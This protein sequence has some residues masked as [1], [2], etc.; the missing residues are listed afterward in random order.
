MTSPLEIDINPAPVRVRAGGDLTPTP[1]VLVLPIANPPGPPGVAGTGY[2]HVQA[3]PSASWIITHNL[4]LY[5]VVSVRV[6]G[7]QCIAE[8][9]YTSLNVV[10]VDFSSPQSGSARLV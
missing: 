4:G 8:V 7:E 6:A 5:P 3:S 9:T 10:T 2:D 1:D